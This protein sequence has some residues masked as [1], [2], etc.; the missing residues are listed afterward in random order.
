MFK[1]IKIENSRMNV[2]EPISYEVTDGEA[3]YA[4]EALVLSDGKLTKAT[5]TPAFIA[6]SAKAVTDHDRRLPVARITSDHLYETSLTEAPTSLKVGDKVTLSS[7]G[8][9]VTATT[10]DGCAEI[11]SLEGA[12]AVG[13]K[14]IVRF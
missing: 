13:D 2:P 1:L 6:L 7:D 5:G 9:G 4:G 11:V 3:V 10:T 14:I 8:M 12:A